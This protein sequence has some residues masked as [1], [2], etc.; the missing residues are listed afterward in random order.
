[1]WQL[2][3][4]GPIVSRLSGKCM[5]V[6]GAALI[7][8]GPHLSLLKCEHGYEPNETD[9]RWELLPAFEV[10]EGV[11]GYCATSCLRTQYL[12]VRTGLCANCPPGEVSM[13]GWQ[14]IA[15]S[16]G[17]YLSVESNACADCPA[18][19]RPSADQTH[20]VPMPPTFDI[21]SVH[22]RLCTVVD[23]AALKIEGLCTLVSHRPDL[24]FQSRAAKECG[25]STLHGC[26]WCA[27][28]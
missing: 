11:F 6:N 20:C 13:D 22:S 14:C 25:K 4:D 12:D 15:C 16:S 27:R 23:E 10:Q 19:T 17:Q 8:P 21:Q 28:C 7:S 2:Q 26:C 3:S 1:M 24:V 18:N 5:D 9:Q